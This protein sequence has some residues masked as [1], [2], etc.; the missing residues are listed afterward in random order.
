MNVGILGAGTIGEK[1]A[2]AIRAAGARVRW[3]VDV[4][5]SRAERLAATCRAEAADS[6]ER[7]WEDSSVDAVV[8][9]TPNRWHAELA[10]Q[11]MQSGKDVLLEKPMALAADECRAINASARATGRVLQI[12]FTHRYTSV[13][14]L[15][16]KLAREGRCGR[17]YH[18]YARLCL[19]RGVPGLG[20]WFTTREIAGGGALIDVGVHL[21]DLALYV[22]GFPQVSAVLGQTYSNFGRR[23][24]GYKFQ[25][26]WA[27]PP[28]Y[29]GVCDV[30]DAACALIRMEDG[31]TLQLDVAWA[32][33]F[34][35]ASTPASAMG[36]LGDRGGMTFELFGD[37][38]LLA[39][40]RDGVLVDE[41]L[42]VGEADCYGDQFAEFMQAVATRTPLGATGEEGEQVQAVVDSIYR[43][44]RN[45]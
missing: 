37:H 36:F 15:A 5:F 38:V 32:G 26:M 35:E 33:N 41:R 6:P 43:A 17:I 20:R 23:M 11:A 16:K 27:G 14:R 22:M 18:S 42:A 12:G 28:N 40:E 45:G 10:I 34:P 2:A 1:H 39:Q 8:V 19:R 21:I 3:V 31:A 13:G 4:D 30:E 29:D 44:G 25:A 7:L 9:A 24:H